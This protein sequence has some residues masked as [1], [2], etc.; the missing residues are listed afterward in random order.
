MLKRIAF[1][2]VLVVALPMMAQ[3]PLDEF[4]KFREQQ[5]AQFN[6]FKDNQQA[7]Y[8]AFR[9]R[10]NA[11]YAGFLRNKWP[12]R[13]G[14]EPVVPQQEKS[15]EPV[16]FEP[17]E[18]EPEPVEVKSLFYFTIPEPQPTPEPIAPVK[19]KP[20]SFKRVTIAY[21]GTLITVGFPEDDDLKLPSLD[22]DDIADAWEK[23]AEER[24]D[25]TVQMALEA[26]A[27]NKLCDWAYLNMLQQITEKKYGKSNEATLMQAF[28]MTQSG[29]RIRMGTFNDKLYLLVASLYDIIGLSYFQLD[30]SKFYVT[31]GDKGLQMYITESK[32]EKEKPL[33]LQMS[34]L[35]QLNS[36]PT[37]KRTLTSKRGVTTSVSVNKNLIDF[38]NTYPQ[39][40]FNG[41]QT[42]RW[43]AFAN[44]PIEPSVTAT[45]YPPLKATIEGMTERQAVD[46]LLN[47]VQ[48]AFEYGYDDEIWGGDRAFFAQETL[49]YPYSDCEDRSILFSHLVRDL[50]GLDVVLLYYPKHLATAVAFNDDV[51]GDWLTYENR[52]YVVCD[53][54]YINAGIGRTMPGMN[55]NEARVI[56]LK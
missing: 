49:F 52:K 7:E 12:E 48:T 24:Y 40:Y 18:Q 34:Q 33:S 26:R 20:Q 16:L 38:F 13:V 21:F 29:Y 45:L 14:E 50:V 51:K 28:L 32:F 53:P 56:G 30:G 1:G 42:T 44:T 5:G 22:E 3:N 15:I 31:N 41:D 36:E 47:W 35:P 9:R 8:D 10:V 27:N 23:L 19:A 11:E 54:T 39:A 55:N 37:P 2:L 43:A 4:N 17:A 6:K 25:I 46:I